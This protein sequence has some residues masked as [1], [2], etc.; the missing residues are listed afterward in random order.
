MRAKLDAT[1]GA[2][3]AIKKSAESEGMAYDQLIGEGNDSGNAKVQA[4]I[5]ALV[6]QTKSIE[7]IVVALDLGQLEFEGSDS[8]DAPEKVFE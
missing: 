5:D 8:L 4:A 7:K 3:A 1:I 2:M 6:D